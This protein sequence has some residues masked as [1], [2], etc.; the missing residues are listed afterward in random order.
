MAMK[1]IDILT[2]TCGTSIVAFSCAFAPGIAGPINYTDLLMRPR[3]NAT[4]RI[5]YGQAP[6]QFAD[7]WMPD[8]SGPHPILVLIHGGCWRADLPGL[9]MMAYAA[10]TFAAWLRGLEHRISAARRT[11]WRLPWK[12]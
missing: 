5:A 4:E 8:G 3:A 10:E 2:M 7:L 6:S 1:T 12:F 11:G 9:E